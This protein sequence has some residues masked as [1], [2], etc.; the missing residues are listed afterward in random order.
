MGY[1]MNMA[2]YYV[3]SH[4][5]EVNN[6]H[7]NTY[8][9]VVKFGNNNRGKYQSNSF[10]SLLLFRQR[11]ENELGDETKK[12]YKVQNIILGR[13]AFDF[14]LVGLA[15]RR[16]AVLGGNSSAATTCSFSLVIAHS[17]GCFW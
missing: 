7:I 16:V 5:M 6:S 9:V 15:G 3:Y 2:S 14:T 12:R 10:S 1:P 13:D 8:I 17:A 11:R 4:E